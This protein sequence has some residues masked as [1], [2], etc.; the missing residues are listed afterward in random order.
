[1]P[2]T[3]KNAAKYGRAGA[4]AAKKASKFRFANERTRTRYGDVGGR[5]YY[6]RDD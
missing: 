1:M 3:K 5:R 4:K 2:F 6:R